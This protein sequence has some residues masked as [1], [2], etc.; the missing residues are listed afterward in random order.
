VGGLSYSISP[1]ATA[2]ARIDDLRLANGKA[3][4]ADK[5]YK[6][7]G[8]A[9]VAEQ[10]GAGQTWGEPIWELMSRYLQ[11]RKVVTVNK[12]ETPVIK[13]LQGNKGME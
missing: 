11:N 9:P 3:L 10:A 1:N 2:G 6:V 4:E 7:A 5:T 12:L 13:G 8:W